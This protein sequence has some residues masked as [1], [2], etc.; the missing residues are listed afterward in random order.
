MATFWAKPITADAIDFR[1]RR[2]GGAMTRYRK[3]PI[4]DRRRTKPREAILIDTLE[5]T[6]RANHGD[7]II[8]GIAG[9]RY[10][11][12]PDI[13]EATYEPVETS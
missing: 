7:W 1:Q 13:F 2:P 12:K 3:R 4:V 9:E 8:T 10:P 6:M 5:G 11:C